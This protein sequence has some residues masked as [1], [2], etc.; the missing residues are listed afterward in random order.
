MSE[1]LRIILAATLTVALGCAVGQLL[2]LATSKSRPTPPTGVDQAV[3]NKILDWKNG[4]LL[5]G[6]FERFLAL[7]SFWIPAHAILG[8]WL[9]FKLAAKWES[10]A[11]VVKVPQTLPKVSD[12]DLFRARRQLGSHVLSRFLLGTLLNVLIGLVASYFGRSIL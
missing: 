6:L 3:W 2:S 4:G 5:I 12:L 11:N 7:A 9:A 8:A 10:W 1:T